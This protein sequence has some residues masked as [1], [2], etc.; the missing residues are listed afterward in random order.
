MQDVYHQ[1][2]GA[3]SSETP[4]KL[5]AR[6]GVYTVGGAGCFLE[7]LASRRTA[8]CEEPQPDTNPSQLWFAVT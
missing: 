5:S 1:P 8:G 2:Y 3:T 7:T 6:V 4:A